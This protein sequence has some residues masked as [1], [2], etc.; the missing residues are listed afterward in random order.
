MGDDT[1]AR[2]ERCAACDLLN[3]CREYCR[4]DPALPPA[5]DLRRATTEGPIAPQASR[6]G[7][8]WPVGSVVAHLKTPNAQARPPRPLP[9][10]RPLHRKVRHH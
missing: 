8:G 5:R 7:P 2:P 3:G 6:R 4:C 1:V 10:A 9:V